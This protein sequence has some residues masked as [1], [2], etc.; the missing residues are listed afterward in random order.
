MSTARGN[1]FWRWSLAA[2]ELPGVKNRLIFLQDSFGFDVNMTLWCC[3]RASEGDRLKEAMLRKADDVIAA[4]TE[5][6]IEALREA[7]RNAKDGPQPIYEQIK[8]AE[9]AAEE[10][11]QHMLY[12]TS[13]LSQPVEPDAMLAAASSNLLLYASLIDAPRREG[14]SSALLRDLISHIFPHDHKHGAHL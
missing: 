6:V 3:W 5:G 4:W 11:A 1:P 13:I 14:F 12:E 8:Q 7:R 9:L 2:Y 10:R